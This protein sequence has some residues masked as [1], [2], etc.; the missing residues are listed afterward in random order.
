MN[1]DIYLYGTMIAAAAS[2]GLFSYLVMVQRA[3]GDVVSI[4]GA[5]ERDIGSPIMKVLLQ[6]ARIIAPLRAGVVDTPAGR[7]L[8]RKLRK[9]GSPFGITVLEF[10]CLRYAGEV[11][12]LGVGCV[13]SEVV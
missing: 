10:V 7:E 3:Q 13:V 5:R 8:E 4:T 2:L 11:A 12:G 6:V 1:P 9:A